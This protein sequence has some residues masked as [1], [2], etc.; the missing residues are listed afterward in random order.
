MGFTVRCAAHQ[1]WCKSLCSA[2]LGSFRVACG[3]PEKKRVGLRGG[4]GVLRD[5]RG[6]ACLGL[7]AVALSLGQSHF[8]R[9]VLPIWTQHYHGIGVNAW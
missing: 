9:T 6:V 3:Q 1:Y 8:D 2:L 5:H 7:V 4:V